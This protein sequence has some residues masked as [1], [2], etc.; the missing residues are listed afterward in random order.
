MKFK[1][2]KINGLQLINT[3]PFFDERGFLNRVYCLN[4][5]KKNKINFSIKQIN[6]S[7]NLTKKTLRGF[8]F[9]SK[10]SY[11]KKIISCLNGSVHNIV[12]DLRKNSSTYLKWQSF[13][14][15]S[16]NK[17]AILVPAMCANAFLS[18][19]KNTT[20]LY[21]HSQYYNK[22]NSIS[23]NYKPKNLNLDWPFSP[24]VISKKDKY[25]KDLNEIL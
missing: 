24:K 2:T 4:E 5:F 23:F 3:K 21:F 13:K 10:P 1:K 6:I 12:I 15:S 20:I 18:L 14:I 11:E 19:E 7:F 17:T 8:H 22:K 25:S 16:R 9:Q